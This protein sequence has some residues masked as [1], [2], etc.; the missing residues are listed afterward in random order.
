MLNPGGYPGFYNAPV[1]KVVVVAVVLCTVFGSIIGSQHRLTLRM[2]DVVNRVQIWRLLSHNFVFT[3]PGELIFGMILLYYFRQFERQLGS[4]RFASFAIITMLVYTAMLASLQLLLPF[5]DPA[6]GP[7]SLIFASLV[8]FYF[9]TPKLYHFQLLGAIEF[10]DKTF[11]YLMAAQLLIVSSWKCLLS[12]FA[13]VSTGILYRIP[14]IRENAD[15]P[16]FL[17]SFCSRYLLPFL[18][19]TRHSSSRGRSRRQNDPNSANLRRLEAAAVPPR[20]TTAPESETNLDVL[21]S[22]GFTGDQAAAA[23]QRTQNDLQR[24]TELLLSGGS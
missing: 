4:S 10:S 21:V 3:T 22:M 19:T 2:T 1:T 17:I 23:L 11:V 14:V 20:Q 6:S 16:E 9:E 12:C 8:F 15:M 5:T 13:A 24:A 18:G 7:Y